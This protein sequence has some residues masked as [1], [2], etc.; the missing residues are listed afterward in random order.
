MKWILCSLLMTSFACERV[1]GDPHPEWRDM[2]AGLDSGGGRGGAGS[3]GKP[4]AA[5]I[6]GAGAGGRAGAGAGGSDSDSG[7]DDE[8]SGIVSAPMPSCPMSWRRRDGQVA[9]TDG[10]ISGLAFNPQTNMFM[11]ASP[12]GVSAWLP[13]QMPQSLAGEVYESLA[14]DTRGETWLARSID[15][16]RVA[17]NAASIELFPVLPSLSRT[18]LVAD[19]SLGLFTLEHSANADVSSIVYFDTAMR[20]RTASSGRFLRAGSLIALNVDPQQSAGLLWYAGVNTLD[21]RL[22]LGRTSRTPSFDAMGNGTI[23]RDSREFR[24]ALGSEQTALTVASEGGRDVAWLATQTSAMPELVRVT[25]SMRSLP[26]PI[27]IPGQAITDI[28]PWP[29]CGVLV[30]H[31]DELGTPRIK[32]V[33]N[34]AAEDLNLTL[35]SAAQKVV[36]ATEGLIA[37]TVGFGD[38]IELYEAI[39][40]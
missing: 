30:S 28:E 15:Y 10:A 12:S 24:F 8:D 40:P 11:Y 32:R 5:P 23:V 16:A 4:E 18:P 34:A 31:V 35:D 9:T 7:M 19:G 22:V 25:A 36:L 21:G 29:G 26:S 38:R 14:V 33:A 39:D 37:V 13:D 17:L 6:G 1:C 3:G 27:A 20:L 2:D